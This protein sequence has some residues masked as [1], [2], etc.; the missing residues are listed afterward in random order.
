MKKI[1][2]LLFIILISI[3]I[4][5]CGNKKPTEGQL[6]EI[7][8][9]ELTNNFYGKNSKDFIFAI[10]NEHKS[11]YMNFK[12]DLERLVKETNQ[13]IYYTYYQHIDTDSALLIFN[14]YDAYFTS[15]SYH[16]VENNEIT[17]TKQY[18]TYDQM[19]TDLAYKNIY[20]ELTYQNDK[21]IKSYLKKAKEEYNKGNIAKS[22][23]SINKIWDTEEGK[24]FFNTHPYLG[25][26]KSWEHF[27]ITEGT[28]DKITYRSLLFYHNSNFF[29]ETLIKEY[30]DNFEKPNS[31]DRYEK[32]YYYIKD[33]I[34]YT[35][36]KEDGTYK[37]RFK[38][39]EITKV[40]LHLFDY[41]YK[42]D[43][44]YDRRV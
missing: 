22:Y 2:K 36:D 9:V 44:I 37:E 1:I 27:V 43:Y 23:D 40:K 32:V 24:N 5:S 35:S 41:K 12:K 28:K 18:T 8:A 19:K 13:T 11:G 42:K 21:E 6:I 39:K 26:I 38:I 34:I 4:C 16:I 10:I 17:L 20:E 29:Y 15:N 14:V 31:L 7:S 3:A 33:D 25:I 30:N